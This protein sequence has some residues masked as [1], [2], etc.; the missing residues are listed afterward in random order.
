MTITTRKYKIYD[1]DIHESLVLVAEEMADRGDLPLYITYK[2][3]EDNY[4]IWEAEVYSA[5]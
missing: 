5:E 3:I 2:G 4:A 1:T